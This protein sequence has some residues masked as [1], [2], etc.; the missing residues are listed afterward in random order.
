MGIEALEAPSRSMSSKY[1]FSPEELKA[2]AELMKAGKWPGSKG[3]EKEGQARSAATRLIDQL[4]A[5]GLDVG[6]V[7]IGEVGS[8]VW[9]TG[10]KKTGFA[11]VLKAGKR[12]PNKKKGESAE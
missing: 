3:Y 7:P 10:D 9:D 6:A 5:A 4:T 12:P 1:D 8:R 11:F 2:A